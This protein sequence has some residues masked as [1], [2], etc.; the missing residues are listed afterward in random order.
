MRSAYKLLTLTVS[1][2][3]SAQEV[4]R[5]PGKMVEVIGLRQ[6]TL[7]M[8]QDSLAALTPRESLTSHACAVVLRYKLGFPDAAAVGYQTMAGRFGRSHRGDRRRAAG[9]RSRAVQAGASR[10]HPSSFRLEVCRGHRAAQPHG[11]ASCPPALP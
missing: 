2:L 7:A 8:L 10:L 6:W 11:G 5:L 3:V 9:F 4:L 1:L